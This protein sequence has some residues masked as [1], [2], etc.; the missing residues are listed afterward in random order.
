MAT[1]FKREK[2]PTG[3]GSVS[4][5]CSGGCSEQ[6]LKSARDLKIGRI[7]KLDIDFKATISREVGGARVSSAIIEHR[8][9]GKGILWANQSR[10]LMAGE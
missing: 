6:S 8:A 5:S 4:G 3:G 1:I 10:S 9:A 2:T 7:N